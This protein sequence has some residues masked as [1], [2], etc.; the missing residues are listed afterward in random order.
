[1]ASWCVHSMNSCHAFV[2][3]VI[4]ATSRGD[5]KSII[6]STISA[7]SAVRGSI[8]IFAAFTLSQYDAVNCNLLYRILG[9]EALLDK[10][11]LYSKPKSAKS[12]RA[13]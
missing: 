2:R 4:E 3:R 13:S 11:P 1:M 9:D 5:V 7:G 8:M 6:R 10:H 12:V